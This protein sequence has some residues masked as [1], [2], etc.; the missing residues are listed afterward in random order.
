MSNAQHSQVKA[1]WYTPETFLLVAKKV[2]G[3]I[4][5]DPAS[6]E[7]GN[8]LVGAQRFITKEQDGLTCEWLPDD[9]H[10]VTIWMNP[11]GPVRRKKGAPMLPENRPLPKLFWERLMVYRSRNQVQHAI[12]A[13]F[14]IEQLQQSQNW[15]VSSMM[16]FPFCIPK[17][18]VQWNAAPDAAEANSPTHASA[19][20][21]V[22]GTIDRTVDFE[23]W[24]SELGNVSLP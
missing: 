23:F 8:I 12:V 22:P 11:P 16:E 15:G 19:F 10:P 13:A 4:D 7:N 18:R 3:T 6:D 24:F 5:L 21:Y 2:L 20:I 9:T 1:E 17:R 14:S